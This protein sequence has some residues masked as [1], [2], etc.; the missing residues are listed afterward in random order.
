[1]NEI[2]IDKTKGKEKQKEEQKNVKGGLDGTY[3]AKEWNF[4][5][6]I[7]YIT[8]CYGERIALYFKFLGYS[9]KSMFLIS[10]LSIPAFIMEISYESND[11]HH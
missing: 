2:I 8:M 1:M 4:S 9:T 10:I 3:L 6:P 7:N 5:I 11:L